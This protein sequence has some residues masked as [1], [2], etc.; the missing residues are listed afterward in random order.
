[1]LIVPRKTGMEFSSE[2]DRYRADNCL[3][4]AIVSVVRSFDRIDSVD[5]YLS[6]ISII[7][8]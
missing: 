5:P 4:R 6:E 7:F 8:C 3:A 2:S 1:M